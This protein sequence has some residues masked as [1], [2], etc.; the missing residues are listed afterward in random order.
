[1]ISFELY[2]AKSYTIERSLIEVQEEKAH[3][4]VVYFRVIE[5]Q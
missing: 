5:Y 1:M 2:E 3:S 4:Q